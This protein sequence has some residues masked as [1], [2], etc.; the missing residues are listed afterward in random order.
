MNKEEFQKLYPNVNT[1]ESE[2]YPCSC[3]TWVPISER[4]P[5]NDRFV[6]IAD[7]LSQNILLGY[8]SYRK[9]EWYLDK[10]HLSYQNLLYFTGSHWQDLPKPPKQEGKNV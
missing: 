2:V 10:E 6:L 5:E 3:N 4:L 1:T 8:Y 7:S 9:R